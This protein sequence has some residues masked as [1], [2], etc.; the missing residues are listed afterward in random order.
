[1]VAGLWLVV[2]PGGALRV[3]DRLNREFS[4]SWLQ[5][6]LDAPRATEHWIYRHHRVVGAALVLATA[7]FFWQLATAYSVSGLAALFA[8][9]A[10][11]VVVDLLAAAFTAVLVLGNTA[12]LL[13]GVV[14]FVR[15][16][17]LKS[18]E[19]WANR[20]IAS[21]K[22]AE[23]LDRRD[24]RAE[25]YAHRYPRRVGIVMLAATLYI[26]LITLVILN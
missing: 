22:A 14:I 25:G 17:A 1:V 15:P 20:W 18:T 26:V 4:I 9:A 12:G 11:A 3:A 21:D 19:G 2:A 6:A 13:L 16:S 7:Y 24:D 8:D 10:P 23:F 5:R